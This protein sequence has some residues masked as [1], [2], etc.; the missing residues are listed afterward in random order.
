MNALRIDAQIDAPVFHIQLSLS[1]GAFTLNIDQHLP[2]QGITVLFGPSGSGKTTFLRCVA[3]LEKAVGVISLGDET[4]QDSSSNYFRP[5]W[6]RELGYVFQEASLFEHLDVRENLDFGV[7]RTKGKTSAGHTQGLDEAIELLGIQGLLGRSVGSLSGG[8]RQRVAIARALATR[9]KVLLLDEPLASIDMARRNEV[10]P[11]LERLHDELHIPI[12]YV[13]H[14][15]DELMRL[16]DHVVMLEEGIIKK[17]GPVSEVM[18]APDFA[19]ANGQ[20]PGPVMDGE[21]IEKN[22]RDQTA[23]VRFAGGNIW[24]PDQSWCVGQKV[25]LNVI[26]RDAA[27]LG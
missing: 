20:D 5:T 8:E 16:A 11:W 13:T 10:L 18:A 3:G 6:Q 15:M 14:S 22:D 17:S 4:W 2:A 9:P 27:D 21:V 25:R 26:V 7:R 12:L 24:V 23:L 19:L 1:L